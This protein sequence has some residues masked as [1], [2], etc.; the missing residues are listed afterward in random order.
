[1]FSLQP[2]QRKSVETINLSLSSEEGGSRPSASEAHK[3]QAAGPLQS[4]AIL[5][6]LPSLPE[7]GHSKNYYWRHL[8]VLHHVLTLAFSYWFFFNSC[9]CV[10]SNTCLS[11]QSDRPECVCVMEE[12]LSVF[13]ALYYSPS[14]AFYHKFLTRSCPCSSTE[15]FQVGSSDVCCH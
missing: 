4:A 7:T 14:V 2:R 3:S 15:I 8:T 12:D 5:F 9:R 13:A 10:Q 6:P 11:P 1:M